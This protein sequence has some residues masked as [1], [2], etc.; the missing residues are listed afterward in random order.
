MLSLCSLLVILQK[1]KQSKTKQIITVGLSFNDLTRCEPLLEKLDT[2]EVPNS[3]SQCTC[4]KIFPQSLSDQY[5]WE[6]TAFWERRSSVASV[7]FGCNFTVSL[8]RFNCRLTL[9]A[10]LPTPHHLHLPT[11]LAPA[12]TL[13]VYRVQTREQMGPLK[14]AWCMPQPQIM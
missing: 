13:H 12:L 2:I 14:M 1:T 5:K 11:V 3:D 10:L 8:I 7:T 9:S 6:K 4:D